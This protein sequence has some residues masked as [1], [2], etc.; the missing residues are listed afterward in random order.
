MRDTY[1]TEIFNALDGI[2]KH[3]TFEEGIVQRGAISAGQ[4]II[5][6]SELLNNIRKKVPCAV[7]TLVGMQYVIGK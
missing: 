4:F 3:S 7:S 5:L 6:E 2:I 1:L